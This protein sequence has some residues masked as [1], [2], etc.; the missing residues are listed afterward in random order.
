[1]DLTRSAGHERPGTPPPQHARTLATAASRP[2]ETGCAGRATPRPVGRQ[3]RASLRTRGEA[4]RE[5]Q[6]KGALSGPVGTPGQA[7]PWGTLPH[8]PSIR[9]DGCIAQ[10][11][12]GQQAAIQ[13]VPR[14]F[15][16]WPCSASVHNRARPARNGG[17][18]SVKTGRP[19]TSRAAALSG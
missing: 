10:P 13:Q 2:A 3:V 11:Q 5:R 4:A 18:G 6:R 15:H 12:G 16:P 7:R 8:A 19:R 17:P 1:M 14:G 9:E